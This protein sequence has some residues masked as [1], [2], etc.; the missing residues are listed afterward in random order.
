[1]VLVMLR[2][3]SSRLRPLLIVCIAGICL[4]AAQGTGS[5]IFARIGYLLFAV[6]GLSLLWAWLGALQ[7]RVTRTVRT[8][9]VAVGERIHEQ[10][11]IWTSVPWSV[12][13]FCDDA[14]IPHLLPG[15]VLTPTRRPTPREWLSIP[16]QRGYVAMGPS[17][18]VVSD[19]FGLF[20][21]ERMLAATD[22][23]IVHPA[24]NATPPLVVGRSPE[25]GRQ[26]AGG[27]LSPQATTVVSVREYRTGDARSRIHW[28]STA[29]R[30]LPMIKEQTHE[31]SAQIWIIYD[32]TLLPTDMAS[33]HE[34]GIAVAATRAHQWLAAGHAV[35]L[36]AYGLHPIVLS[37][38]RG[39]TQRLLI[40][41]ALAMLV[42]EGHTPLARVIAQVDW[43][44]Q[45]HM[46]TCVITHDCQPD[47]VTAFGF[48]TP[49]QSER[50][51]VV[52]VAQSI[53]VQQIMPALQHAQ[54][55]TTV[56]VV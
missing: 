24:I 15:F 16:D 25:W 17:R 26:Q 32:A 42:C 7:V 8:P 48:A 35:G 45:R 2:L 3:T 38:A 56:V 36:I 53:A 41:D 39:A 28:R 20:R 10:I 18:I 52:L 13:E 54:I 23:V 27:Q 4:V 47:W 50:L 44:G 51:A 43:R 1:M 40:M 19:P 30:G 12:V 14:P 31:P 9:R 33:L 49:A 11:A 55:T 29:K 5:T 6:V 21:V 22:A 37:P 34:R 46:T